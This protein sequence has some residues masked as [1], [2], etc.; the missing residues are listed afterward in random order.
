VQDV[1]HLALPNIGQADSQPGAVGDAGDLWR[2]VDRLV[3]RAPS[4]A[5]LRSHKLDLF[6]ARRWRAL[7]RPVPAELVERER[8]AAVA[9]LTAP[10]LLERVR[11]AYDGEL[12]PLKGPHVAA[13]FP[14][15]G[16]RAF[17]DLD[18]LATDALSAQASLVAAGFKEVGDASAYVGIHHLRPLVCPG[19]PLFVEIHSRPKWPDGLQAPAARELFAAAV[20]LEGRVKSLPPAHHALVLAAHSWSHEPLRRLRD[21]LDIAVMADLAGQPDVAAL[22]KEWRIERLWRTTIGAANAVFRDAARP[23]ELRLWAQNLERARERTVLEN[24][25]QRWFSDFSIMPFG[26]A[27]A[28][29]PNTVARELFPKDAEGWDAKLA[30]TTRAVRNASRRRSEHD[31]ELDRLRRR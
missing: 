24:H 7:G 8:R 28:R 30:R 15:P 4:L 22:A 23:W 31:D 21:L 27:A 14:D 6:A 17:G 13:H 2:A 29:V 19:F 3:D 10:L 25:L 12:I 20:P 9:V 26:A 1:L 16:L 18:L 5:D 11:S